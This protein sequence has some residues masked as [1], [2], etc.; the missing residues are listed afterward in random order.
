MMSENMPCKN[1]LLFDSAAPSCDQLVFVS[2]NLRKSSLPCPIESRVA[3]DVANQNVDAESASEYS[4]KSRRCFMGFSSRSV[5]K[6]F[7]KVASHQTHAYH[8]RELRLD[9]S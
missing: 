1:M 9:Y 5:L 8:V 7:W 2:A 4:G 3:V 6:R